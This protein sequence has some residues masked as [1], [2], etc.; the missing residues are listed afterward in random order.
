[1]KTWHFLVLLLQGFQHQMYL[2]YKVVVC[3]M[4]SPVFDN[5]YRYGLKIFGD[6]NGR[7]AE[8]LKDNVAWLL[9]LVYVTALGQTFLTQCAFITLPTLQCVH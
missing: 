8:L 4:I 6:L 1:L 7:T 3:C 2:L 9:F 5:I